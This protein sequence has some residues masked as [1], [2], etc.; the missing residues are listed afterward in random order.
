MAKALLGHVGRGADLM[1]VDEVRRLRC[2]VSEL[3]TE[4]SQLTATHE[5]LVSSVHVD[6]DLSMLSYDEPAL[7]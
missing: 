5:A 1:L 3:E 6:D 4:L 7:T 2:R